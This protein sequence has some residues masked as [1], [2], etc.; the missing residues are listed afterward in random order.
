MKKKNFK[1]LE[2]LVEKGW[3]QS[4]LVRMAGLSSETRLS[5]IIHYL[6]MPSDD[7][8]SRIC[9]TLNLEPIDIKREENE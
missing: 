7:E 6:S 8:V 9:N 5:R 3:R 1:I 2:K 4:D